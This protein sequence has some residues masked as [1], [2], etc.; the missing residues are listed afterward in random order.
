MVFVV[1]SWTF[2]KMDDEELIGHISLLDCK[3]PS[4]LIYR[5]L[6]TIRCKYS[7]N[8]KYINALV[9]HELVA[10]L[11]PL[12][13]RP[14]SKIVDMSLSVLGNLLMHRRPRE[15]VCSTRIRM[16][17]GNSILIIFQAREHKGVE[18]LV[19]IISTLAEEKILGRVCRVIANLSQDGVNSREFLNLGIIP[20]LLKTL[21]DVKSAKAKISVIRAIRI[22]SQ[23]HEGRVIALENKAV[24]DITSYLSSNDSELLKSVC[25]SLSVLTGQTKSK[26]MAEQIGSET[27]GFKLL[28]DLSEHQRKSMWIPALM[29]LSN[30]SKHEHLRPLLGNVGAITAMTDRAMSEDLSSMEFATVVKA[31]CH[32]SNESVNRIK[33]RESGALKL[34]VQL[35]ASDVSRHK[36]VR[37]QII[38]CLPRFGY[39]ALSLKVMGDEGIVSCLTNILDSYIEK[40]RYTHCCAV[41]DDADAAVPSDGATPSSSTRS[42]S[43][44]DVDMLDLS[45]TTCDTCDSSVESE[46]E[47][48]CKDVGKEMDNALSQKPKYSG[49][50]DA[51]DQ[52]YL[53][54]DFALQFLLRVFEI[55]LPSEE[56]TK[57]D[58]VKALVR[59]ICWTKGPS[60]RAGLILNRIAKSMKYIK[61][62]LLQG[63]FPWLRLE[64]SERLY[65]CKELTCLNCQNV[66]SVF[67]SIFQEFVFTAETGYIEGTVCHTLLRGSNEI[68]TVMTIGI[69]AIIM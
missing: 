68:R 27:G 29:T 47:I 51:S 16:T 8:D 25:K 58:N 24:A 28:V 32:F 52:N 38:F 69:V 44:S 34:F 42:T 48:L 3:Q 30:L 15:Q 63:L 22:L 39:D 49:N 11:I 31:L 55:Q 23:T 57:A 45:S 43:S 9:N 5:T 53:V 61:P 62:F 67:T 56:L 59:Y 4:D 66:H 21:K 64:V 19:R 65:G 26:D 36:T 18:L 60:Y 6:V 50:V 14:N 33:L 41:D 35:L 20:L 37:E 10:K 2:L 12:L 54:I 1:Q 7:V 40:H 13:Q 17:T 46:N